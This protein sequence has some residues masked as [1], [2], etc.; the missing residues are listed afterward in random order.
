[1][2]LSNPLVSIIIPCYN[3]EQYIIECLDSVF[4]QTYSNIEIICVDNNS[5]DKTSQLI[6]A[7]K[8]SRE[9]ILQLLFEEKKGAP[10]ARNKGLS[11]AKGEWIQFLDADDLILPKKI[12]HQINLLSKKSTEIAFIAA[13]YI[14]RTV[15]GAEKQSVLIKEDKYFV[16]FINNCGITSSNLWNK[17]KLFMCG[18]WNEEITSSQEADLMFRLLLQKDS[19]YLIDNSPNTIIQQRNSGQISQSEPLKRWVLYVTLRINYLEELLRLHIIDLN[20][21][22]RYYD[23]IVISLFQI[24]KFDLKLANSIFSKKIS[25][26]WRS[27]N[28]YGWNRM[29]VLFIKKMGF[30]M[31]YSAFLNRL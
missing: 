27:Q 24:A 8:E 9:S 5:T 25:H 12:E 13:S 6:N 21:A 10:Y 31:Y 1:M 4:R 2:S 18:K 22:G 19:Y 17:K 29:K 14:T 15:N 3:V 11:V 28:S 30:K 20:E 26:N 16:P 7:Y 23:F